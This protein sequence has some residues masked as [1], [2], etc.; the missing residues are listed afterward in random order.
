MTNKKFLLNIFIILI[1]FTFT[2]EI[3]IEAVK[4][5]FKGFLQKKTSNRTIMASLQVLRTLTPFVYQGNLKHNKENFPSHLSQIQRYR[6]YIEDQYNYEDLKY[7]HKTIAFSGCELIAAYN[8]LF[9]LTGDENID[10]PEMIHY[11]EN[12]GIL[13]YGHLGTA[14]QAVDLYFKRKGFETKRS[15]KRE[16]YS[17]IEKN[18]DA[19]ILTK[20]N[21]ID[22]ITQCI[23]TVCITKKNG[24]FHVHN[25]SYYGHN[26]QYDS[27]EDVLNRIDGGLAKDIVLL[28][29]KK[30]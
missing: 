3:D 20:F 22:D 8:A 1:L 4:E 29:I 6:G 24:K 14:P 10:F 13:L 18:Y 23:H 9:D 19:F 11:F 12:D 26:I 25:N 21:D 15:F 28:G 30:K 7:G 2:V 27:I 5:Y 17:N 16:E